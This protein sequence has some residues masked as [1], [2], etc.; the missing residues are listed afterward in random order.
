[1]SYRTLELYEAILAADDIYQAELVRVYGKDACNKRYQVAP[2]ADIR[3]NAARV[4]K[5]QADEVWL[6][7]MT[8]RLMSLGDTK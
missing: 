6:E 4:A 5:I 8:K 7:N 1:M 3:V 2:H